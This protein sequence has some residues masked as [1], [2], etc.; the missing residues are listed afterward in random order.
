MAA[1]A[2]LDRLA[3]RIACRS[4][5]TSDSPRAIRTI[6]AFRSPHISA[7]GTETERMSSDHVGPPHAYAATDRT[8]S[9][10]RIGPPDKSGQA[11]T[12]GS[13][14]KKHAANKHYRNIP[15]SDRPSATCF[16]LATGANRTPLARLSVPSVRQPGLPS[17]RRRRAAN[18][19]TVSL[20]GAR[21]EH[22]LPEKSRSTNVHASPVL[23]LGRKTDASA[24]IPPHAPPDPLHNL[25]R[26][27]NRTR[28]IR[29]SY[30]SAPRAQPSASLRPEQNERSR[31]RIPRRR[32]LFF[33]RLPDV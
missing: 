13:Y 33:L 28:A 31:P 26:P 1:A 15:P 29:A 19:R 27:S 12:K 8:T 22:P 7:S 5:R 9:Q 30:A 25:T 6:P 3:L 23:T 14:A 32:P 4:G 20:S 18:N 21:I 24:P 16:R 10:A 11:R 17:A 2:G